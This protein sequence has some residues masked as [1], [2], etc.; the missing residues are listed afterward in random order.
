VRAHILPGTYG[1]S[2]LTVTLPKYDEDSLKSIGG[3]DWRVRWQYRNKNTQRFPIVVDNQGLVPAG[4]FLLQPDVVTPI[5]A[6]CVSLVRCEVVPC[7]L[8]CCAARMSTAC[9]AGCK[10]GSAYV[11]RWQQDG[12]QLACA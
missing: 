2:N 5:D 3:Y 10:R 8:S 11:Q 7:A 12:A 6:W 4:F 9:T 1:L